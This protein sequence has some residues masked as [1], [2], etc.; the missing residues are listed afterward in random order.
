MGKVPIEFCLL[1]SSSCFWAWGGGSQNNLGLGWNFRANSIL[2][3]GEVLS[4]LLT[5]VQPEI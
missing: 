1:L 5:L 4:T 3:I 2:K